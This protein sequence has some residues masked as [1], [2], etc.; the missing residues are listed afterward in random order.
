MKSNLSKLEQLLSAGIEFA[1]L[2]RGNRNV[3]I[4]VA[5]SFAKECIAELQRLLD[6]RDSL[7]A[8]VNKLKGDSVCL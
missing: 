7:Q 1:E 6:K 3:T 4:S 8:E 2:G 5:P